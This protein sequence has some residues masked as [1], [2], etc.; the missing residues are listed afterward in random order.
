MFSRSEQKDQSDFYFPPHSDLSPLSQSLTVWPKGTLPTLK[1]RRRQQAL[2]ADVLP[3]PA[4]GSIRVLFS[5]GLRPFPSQSE[6]DGGCPK[7]AANIE[8]ESKATNTVSFPPKS[9]LADFG[10]NT[11]FSRS[12]QKDQSDFYFPPHSDLSPLSQNL[13]IVAHEHP[14]TIERETKATSTGSFPS[15]SNLAVFG[16]NP[17]FSRSEQKDQSDFYFPPHSDL[18][19]LSQS[20]TVW[21]KGT[22]PTLKNRRRQQALVADVLPLPVEASIRVLFS[23]GLRPI[24]S[25]SEPESGFP[26]HAANIERQT[27]TKSTVSFPPKSNLAVLGQ[28][29]MF[30][31][32]EQKHQSDFYFP[33][34]S[35]L[36]PL[37]QNLTIVAHDILPP[38]K[39]RRRQKPQLAS[40]RNPT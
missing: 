35:D 1:N 34:H 11:M 29:P 30:S 27:K 9:K 10:Q 23:A 17:T 5:A 7:H 24:P 36:S 13:T 16:Q 25:Q 26:R 19:P 15:D 2:V 38:F 6:P 3:L 32:S 33:P 37:S 8:R 20:L 12:E 28:N 40:R 14:V 31:R 4:E 22:L 39:D 21:P 18:S